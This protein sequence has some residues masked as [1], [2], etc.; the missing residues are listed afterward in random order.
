MITPR[1]KISF[2][3]YK[4]QAFSGLAK[5]LDF[6]VSQGQFTIILVAVSLTAAF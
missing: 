6:L 3:K 2:D 5:F 1:K 4:T